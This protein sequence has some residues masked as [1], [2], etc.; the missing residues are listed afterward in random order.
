MKTPHN[1]S[2]GSTTALVQELDDSALRSGH[3]LLDSDRAQEFSDWMDWR[4]EQ[5]EAGFDAFCTPRS[6]RRSLGR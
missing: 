4:L 5:L 1:P 3:A 2:A 6:V